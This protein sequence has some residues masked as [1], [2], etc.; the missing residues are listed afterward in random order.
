VA[1]ESGRSLRCL[2]ETTRERT[3]GRNRIAAGL[4]RWGPVAGALLI[5][6]YAA[7]SGT[8][9]LAVFLE[10]ED[11][12][13]AR[14]YRRAK[15]QAAPGRGAALVERDAVSA[16]RSQRARIEGAQSALRSEIAR[17]APAVKELYGLKHLA[18][19][20]AVLADPEDLDRL[21]GLPGVRRVRP[22]R[23]MEPNP[24]AA[25][26]A[27][28]GA[29]AAW[30]VANLKGAGIRIGIIDSGIDYLHSDLGG[31]GT[32]YADN[33]VTRINDLPGLY[34]NAKVVG[35]YDFCGDDYDGYNVARPDPD[36][37]DCD[38]HG[39]SVAGVAGGLGV[40]TNGE[41]YGGPYGTN[42]PFSSL[43]IPPGIAPGA[44]LYALRV[45]GCGGETFLACQALD[46]AMDPDGDGSYTDRLDVVN[47]SLG[48]PFSPPDDLTALAV[49]EAVQAGIAVARSGGNDYETFFTS[50]CRGD[51]A[52]ITAAALHDAYWTYAVLVHSPSSIT[53]RYEAAGA[54]FG[55]PPSAS[56]L[57]NVVYADPPLA[58][59]PLTN[60]A[61]VSNNICLVDRGSYDFDVKV[62]N[63]QDAGALA[64][65][66]VNNRAGP[67]SSMSGDDATI[68]IPSL[69][70]SQDAGNAIKS[71][72]AAGVKA[73]MAGNVFI[74]WSNRADTIVDYS[75]QGPALNGLL[76]PDLSAPTEI[77][78]PKSGTG[79]AGGHFNGTSCAAPV[80]AGVLALLREQF[81][82]DT[83][84]ELKARL[85]N[86]ATHDL[87]AA[88]NGAPPRW[89]PSRAGTGRLD[90]TNA[91]A[92]TVIAYATNAPGAVQGSFG[93]LAAGVVTQVER[94][95]RI[96]NRAASA[97]AVRIG[98]DSVADVPGAAFSFPGGTNLSLAAGAA[99]TITVRLTATPA[100]LRNAHAPAVAETQATAA[101]VLPRHWLPEE[102]G[103]LT[104]TP[105]SGPSLRLALHA[106]VRPASSLSCTSTQIILGAASGSFNLALAGQGV[107]TGGSFPSNWVSMAGA[108]G[109]Q[110][111]GTNAAS[112]GGVRG[113]GVMTDWKAVEAGG[114]AFSNAW[115]AFGLVL[116]QPLPSLNGCVIE[117][118]V[119]LDSDGV[120]DRIVRSGS[121]HLTSGDESDVLGT[122]VYNVGASASTYQAPLHGMAATG[123]PTAVFFSSAC[124]L[125]ARVGDL[126]LSTTNTSFRYHVETLDVG[127]AYRDRTPARFYDA[128]NPGLWWPTAPGQ[129]IRPAQSGTNIVVNYDRAACSR[130]GLT[131]VLLIHHLNE[132]AQQAEFI[133][134]V[135]TN[136]VTGTLYVAVSGASTAPYASWAAAA[137]NPC[138]AANLAGDGA[139]VLVSNGAYGVVQPVRVERGF[140]LRSVNGAAVTVVN[141]RGKNRCLELN[142]P[143]ARVEN[144]SFSNGAAPRGGAAFI[145][146]GGGRMEGC[147]VRN[148][149]ATNSGGGVYLDRAGVLAR[150]VLE[151][152][153][154]ADRGGAAH[155][156][157]GG[158][159]ESCLLSGNSA[160]GDGGGAL[161]VDGG[162]LLN[163]TGRLNRSQAHGGAVML[164][165]DGVLRGGLYVVNTGRW[166]GA[167]GC[168]QGG[169]IFDAT[170]LTNTA[171]DHGG[172]LNLD[173]GGYA[174]NC[175]LRANRAND[176]GGG[177]MVY[178]GGGIENCLLE[179]NSGSYGG[180]AVCWGADD[181]G[182]L[183]R[184]TVR[185]NACKNAGGGVRLYQGGIVRDTVLEYN[186]A[187]EGG[188]VQTEEGTGWVDRCTIRHNY[189]TNNGGGIHFH[190]DG[191][192]TDC[193]IVSNSSLNAAG[194]N[195]YLGG[196]VNR[197]RVLRNTA[198]SYGGGAFLNGGGAVR[199]TLV[200]HNSAS[201]GGGFF[202]WY[203][204][205]FINC[206]VV[207][208]SVSG[209]GGGAWNDHGGR[210]TNCV[211]Y[212]NVAPASP[213][214]TNTD[215]AAVSFTATC[216][217]PLPPGPGNFTNPPFLSLAATNY[218]VPLAGSPCINAGVTLPWMAG[219]NDPAG[220]KRIVGPAPEVGAFEYP[221]TASGV[222]AA[223][224]MAHS[225][226]TDGRSDFTDDDRDGLPNRDEWLCNTDPRNAASAL[227]VEEVARAGTGMVVRWQSVDG[228]RYRLDRSTNLVRGFDQLVKTNIPGVAP[229][230]TETDTTAT[231][232]GPWLYRIV[233]E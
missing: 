222:S 232:K 185:S 170:F 72:L 131:G 52:V 55:P 98:Y 151:A 158:L 193:L 26:N 48:S 20:V 199:N 124:F 87:Y 63:A 76:K 14:V 226:F 204:G 36:P 78:A 10:L 142:H 153:T 200:S 126:G 103:Y 110:W 28:V 85:M 19:G 39:T 129:F 88:T 138:D 192:A 180:G 187:N 145:H 150:C 51:R 163:C 79:G 15:E 202:C 165:Q 96:H 56:I 57:T 229:M 161:C 194:V 66:V 37:M 127:E 6:S 47:L 133:P 1:S 195:C 8:R 31:P 82:S 24:V 197:C 108:F 207:S 219:E 233:L 59:A 16:A 102:S 122:W 196:L 40:T 91:L 209:D 11:E 149:S 99:T 50:G 136:L 13:A 119:D 205:D 104:I 162:E 144:L 101:G 113:C 132:P 120:A 152:N 190:N 160:A 218:G 62:K 18:A 97:Q 109:L 225:L 118:H 61:A 29:A 5:A 168:Y 89:P 77:M 17:A 32:G 3:M 49:D 42:T 143:N 210:F 176:A 128:F 90:V 227:G 135:Q 223:W 84:E 217:W 179:F 191:L 141:G 146:A 69:M 224:L 60:A 156:A 116:S 175:V 7:A 164:D 21:R 46:W 215:A 140:T 54:D 74:V 177:A 208:N 65:I 198:S 70:I 183:L 221:F 94:Q 231:G 154:S 137:T 34:P 148:S 123:M 114:G 105:P 38:G 115:L 71:N 206:T 64:V 22:I 212:H 139:V 169:S 86:A 75:S 83:V 81:P 111:R 106:A 27:F 167:V 172:A 33:D 68:V 80:I 220:M 23:A 159:L 173:H 184:C 9:P 58:G 181:H 203:G 125:L 130:D 4:R 93:L 188:G 121:H 2:P 230:N 174:S 134:I 67:P 95:V 107:N 73:E 213:N 201:R 155:L 211:V 228:K 41:S 157:G 92:A 45:F 214:Y 30:G 53:G 186:R 216:T 182:F 166:G 35:G 12:P 100:Q 189:A 117:A 44:K 178:F 43:R 112:Y 171:T 25:V 147:L